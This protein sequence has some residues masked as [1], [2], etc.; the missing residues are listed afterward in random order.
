MRSTF[1]LLLLSLSIAVLGCS[2]S[3]GVAILESRGEGQVASASWSDPAYRRESAS[4][5][6]SELSRVNRQIPTVPPT[7]IR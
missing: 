5:W 2:P 7:P 4:K 3:T 1:R 6:L